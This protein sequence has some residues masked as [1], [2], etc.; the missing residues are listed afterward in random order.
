VKD[1][2]GRPIPSASAQLDGHTVQA[3]PGG[4]ISF[5][6]L[7][8]GPLALV[9]SAPGYRTQ[10]LSPELQ[11][12][13]NQIEVVLEPEPYAH[14][15]TPQPLPENRTGYDL[16]LTVTDL[17][18]RPL[19]QASV[20][21]LDPGGQPVGDLLTPNAAGV[22]VLNDLPTGVVSLAV[23]APGYL[24]LEQG[25]IIEKGEPANL[26]LALERDTLG[27][28]PVDA[29]ASGEELLYIEDFNDGQA[30]GWRNISAAVESNAQNGWSK[31]RMAS[32]PPLT[33]WKMA[34]SKMRSGG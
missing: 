22:L 1:P 21:R 11:T 17:E 29:C 6:G 26:T 3:G 15:A 7:G 16:T 33:S 5:S 14:T 19:G 4:I 18:G 20:S 31:P 30:Q 34:Y 13:D 24:P 9:V 10:E 28:D 12:G 32:A 2:G 27:L 8:P 25:L 23:S